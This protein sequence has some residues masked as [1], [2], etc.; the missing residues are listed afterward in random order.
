MEDGFPRRGKMMMET[1][2]FFLIKNQA[3]RDFGVAVPVSSVTPKPSTSV[4][5]IPISA[6]EARDI[7]RQCGR[8]LPR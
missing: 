6:D 3:D 4:S 2:K 5:R 1:K 8:R 7:L